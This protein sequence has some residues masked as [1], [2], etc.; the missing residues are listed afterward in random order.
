MAQDQLNSFL[1]V[2][3][4]L[5]VSAR[6]VH[7]EFIYFHIDINIVDILNIKLGLN[8]RNNFR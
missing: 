7:V 1:M 8:P 6:S 4:D 2:A 3:E 5:K